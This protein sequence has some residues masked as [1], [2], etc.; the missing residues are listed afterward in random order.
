MRFA[1]TATLIRPTIGPGGDLTFP[2]GSTVKCA[3][4][5]RKRKQVLAEGELFEV[6]AEAF[7]PKGTDVQRRDRLEL[8]SGQVNGPARF[9]VLTVVTA[10]D[11]LGRVHHVGLELRDAPEPVG[12]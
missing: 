3:L 6:T 4:W 2:A 5:A 9:E 8:A 10:H 7:V 11:D 1:Q 12:S